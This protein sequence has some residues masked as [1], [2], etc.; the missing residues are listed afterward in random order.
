MMRGGG[1]LKSQITVERLT[2]LFR[3][4]SRTTK[5]LHNCKGTNDKPDREGLV[6]QTTER[7]KSCQCHKDLILL[8]KTIVRLLGKE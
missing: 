7:N 5:K 2:S 8:L 4:G 1:L 3:L 6:Q